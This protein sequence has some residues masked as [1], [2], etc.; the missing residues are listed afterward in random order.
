[1]SKQTS[2]ESGCNVFG[3]I[4]ERLDSSVKHWNDTLLDGGQC[5]LLS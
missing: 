3:E 1:M 4:A 5:Q 2:I